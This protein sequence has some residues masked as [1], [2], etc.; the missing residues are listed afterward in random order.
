MPPRAFA[1]LELIADVAESLASFCR[2]LSV[3]QP[4]LVDALYASWIDLS[5]AL[6]AMLLGVAVGWFWRDTEAIR[7]RRVERAQPAPDDIARWTP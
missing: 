6:V 1:P 5:L 3:K 7:E 4:A 2:A